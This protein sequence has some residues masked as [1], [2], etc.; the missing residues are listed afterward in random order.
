M[1]MV[2]AARITSFLAVTV[3]ALAALV[4]SVGTNET[5]VARL[6]WKLTFSTRWPVKVW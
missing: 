3:S 4:A 1:W 5:P 2:P 6:L